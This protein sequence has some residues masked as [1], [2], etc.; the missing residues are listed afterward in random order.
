MRFNPQQSSAISIGDK[1]KNHGGPNH[2]ILDLDRIG[3]MINVASF[4]QPASK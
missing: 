2:Y 1:L 3:P 4:S